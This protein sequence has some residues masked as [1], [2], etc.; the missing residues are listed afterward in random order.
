MATSNRHRGKGSRRFRRGMTGTVVAA[1]AMAGLT[2]SA[3]PDGPLAPPR[4]GAD[5]ESDAGGGGWD[6][7]AGSSADSYHTELPPLRAGKGAPAD[8]SEAAAAR[9]QSGIPA[10][11]LTAYRRAEA[12]LAATDPGCGLPWQLLAAIGKVES[13]QARG[14]RVD[15]AGTTLTP[16]LGPVLNGTGFARISDTD[17]GAYDGDSTYDR[18][19]GPMQ[20]IPSTWAR[21][22][23]DGNS[24][25]RADPGNIHDAALAAGRY[26]CAGDRDLANK[27]DLDRAILSYNHSAVYLR[28]VL[29]WL[30]FY[31]RGVHEVPD[32][33]GPLPTG[34]GPGGRTPTTRPTGVVV[35][36][37]PSNPSRPRPGGSPSPNP[38]R[39]GPT[40]SAPGTT[41][42]PSDP[43][44]T[45]TP[46]PT[47]TDPE[48]PTPTPAP[49]DTPSPSPTGPSVP[50][51]SPSPSD[52]EPPEPCAPRIT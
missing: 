24:D 6:P 29:A 5:P 10:T 4:H 17:D 47:S 51:P 23:A 18:A 20:F 2:A 35:G 43:G 11:V 27:A 12:A 36:P 25:G 26:L 34:P 22:G 40:P 37:P 31:R 1:L 48:C 9:T 15:A 46:T 41:P 8:R 32:G 45:P 39:P 50:S 52:S 38:P 16:I 49:S 44:P 21:W 19:V 33:R 14:G 3:A 42:A 30:D 28:T 13:G 7:P